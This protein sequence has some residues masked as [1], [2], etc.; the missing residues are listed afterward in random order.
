VVKNKNTEVDNP[1]ME[2]KEI[3][4]KDDPGFD[5]EK[6]IVRKLKDIK[7]YAEMR[8]GVES[9]IKEKLVPGVD[10]GATD[11]RS[12]IPTLK[13]PGSE[14]ICI[15][16]GLE[17]V[18]MAD[19]DS[20]NMF[21]KKDGTISLI[22][23]LMTHQAKL[24]AVELIASSG[25][26]YTLP[27]CSMFAVAEGRGAGTLT[28]RSNSNPNDLIKRVQKRAQVDA[29]LRVA[30]LSERFTQDMEEDS[31][32]SEDEIKAEMEKDV[33][34]EKKDVILVSPSKVSVVKKE[35]KFNLSGDDDEDDPFT[36]KLADD[37]LPDF[38]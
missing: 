2:S 6:Y 17:P 3:V 1:D 11:S 27:I 33:E 24:R 14:K 36:M 20:W 10:Y 28:E 30:G 12:K 19:I 25:S 34:E 13:K 21:G 31:E 5:A 18:F 38:N 37:E 26:Q 23:F 8:E 4:L 35:R 29:T 15:L 9:F 7:A 16:L 32:N 22:C